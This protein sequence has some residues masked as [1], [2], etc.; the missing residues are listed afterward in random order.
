MFTLFLTSSPCGHDGAIFE[1]NGFRE[2]LLRQ[3][4]GEVRGLYV[5]SSPDDFGGSECASEGMRTALRDCGVNIAGWTLLDRRNMTHAHSLVRESNLVILGGGHV[6]TQ[7][8]F[9]QE[10]FLREALLVYE[11]VLLTISAGSMNCAD[12]VYSIPELPGEVR[13]PNYRRFFRGMGLTSIQILPH[14]Y[15]WKDFVLD[16]MKIYNEVAAK[17]SMGKRFYVF[18]DG[19]YLYSM[20]GYEEIR[21]EAFLMEN[22]IFRKICEDGQKVLLPII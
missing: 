18:P 11:G 22:G 14:Y 17:D 3:L 13:D 21:G 6:P 1:K 4:G 16:G 2:E 10:M 5:T 7:H 8:S 19:T 12:E 20:F 15:E 9:F